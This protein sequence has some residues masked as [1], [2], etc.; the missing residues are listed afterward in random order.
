MTSNGRLPKI[1]KFNYFSNH[2]SNLHFF[3]TKPCGLLQSNCL[4]LVELSSSQLVIIFKPLFSQ[5]WINRWNSWGP[6]TSLDIKIGLI[7]QCNI[8]M[9]YASFNVICIIWCHM[10]IW[11][12]QIWSILVSKEASGPQKFHPLIRFWLKNCLKMKINK[13]MST[14]NCLYRFFTSFVFFDETLNA[15]WSN[16]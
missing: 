15:I 6:D 2:W 3:V 7:G 13:K 9:S 8:L 16:F 14:K 10:R 5:N 1:A 11:H 4:S 12:Q